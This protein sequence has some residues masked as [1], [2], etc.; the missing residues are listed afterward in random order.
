MTR[1]LAITRRWASIASAAALALVG[2]SAAT[3]AP[4]GDTDYL[5]A[6]GTFL[7]FCC[8]S[9]HVWVTAWRDPRRDEV[10]GGFLFYTDGQF[11]IF[12][13][14][15]PE[16]LNVQGREAAV[17]TLASSYGFRLWFKFVFR[18]NRRSG[19]DEL[20]RFEFSPYPFGEPLYCDFVPG[21]PAQWTLDGDVNIHDAGS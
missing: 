21:Q 5:L 3:A 9:S 2:S 1:R 8:D 15:E 4:R 18:D 20:V 14:H 19:P 12:R 16:C 6:A 10:R 17:V 13:A 11:D 7:G